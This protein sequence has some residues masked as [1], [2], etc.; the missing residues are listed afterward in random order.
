MRTHGTTRKRP[1][2]VFEEQERGA[3]KPLVRE[4]FEP[5]QW[6][7]A[8]VHPDHHVRFGNALYS[9]PTKYVGRDVVVRGDRKLVRVYVGGEQVKVHPQQE[10]GNRSTDYADYPPQKAPY[11]M[12]DPER[13]IREAQGVG[14]H[15]GRFMERLLT[16]EFPWAKLRQAYKL[17]RLAEKYGGRRTDAACQR[18]L[19]FDLVDVWRVER[20]IAQALEQEAAEQGRPAQ[21][22]VIQLPLRFLRPRES[23]VHRERGEE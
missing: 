13:M 2:V 3:L 10:P 15:M 19:A 7:C 22:Q 18:A 8:K 17:L 21:T 5:P 9:V 14:E 23:F 6:A 20:I 1:L 4:R 16:G 11:A 12:R